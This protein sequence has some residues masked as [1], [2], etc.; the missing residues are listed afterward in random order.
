MSHSAVFRILFFF[1]SFFFFLGQ[2]TLS[3][4][5]K[6]VCCL[7]WLIVIAKIGYFCVGYAIV[8]CRLHAVAIVAHLLSLGYIFANCAK[9]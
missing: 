9:F 5:G 3:V 1:H 8:E 4:P 2:L 6:I 7:N